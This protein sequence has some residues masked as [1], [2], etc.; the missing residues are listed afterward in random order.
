MHEDKE[1]V[2][3]TLRGDK[4]AFAMIIRK[5]QP[6]LLNYIGRMV[7]DRELALDFS[8]DVFLKAY[9]SLKSFRHRFS[10]STWLFK[11]ASNYLIDYWRKKKIPALSLDQ[12]PDD[13]HPLSFEVRDNEPS[14]VRKFEIQELRRTIDRA[15]ENLPS[16]YRELFIWRHI[17][18]FSYEEMAEIKG[19]PV[20]TVK[21]R[22]FQAKEML[23]Q[24]LE[25]NP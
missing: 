21:N 17:N 6:P 22:V 4:E 9:A 2:K 25:V 13:A 15:L 14:I 16:A 24:L 23:R 10:F 19:L 1:L 12:P 11:I 20:G 5:Y 8:Q 18:G 7:R 3:K